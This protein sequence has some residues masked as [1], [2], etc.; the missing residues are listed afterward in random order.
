MRGI[1]IYYETIKISQ[2]PKD[3]DVGND[4]SLYAPQQMSNMFGYTLKRIRVINNTYHKNLHQTYCGNHG[5][6]QGHTIIPPLIFSPEQAW[7]TCEGSRSYNNTF[8]PTIY[9]FIRAIVEIIGVVKLMKSYLPHISLPEP[10]QQSW[11]WSSS[12]HTYHMY[13]HQSY[14]GNPVSC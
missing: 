13:H 11:K 8:E 2:R 4:R 5:S 12:C 7:Q 9:I 14:H 10:L 6:C 1:K 3:V